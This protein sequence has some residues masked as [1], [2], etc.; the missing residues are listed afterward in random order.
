MY[1]GGG[2]SAQVSLP[3]GMP[4]RRD[5]PALCLRGIPCRRDT[6]HAPAPGLGGGTP[7]APSRAGAPLQKYLSKGDA[8][9]PAVHPRTCYL[10]KRSY[11][12]PAP[13]CRPAVTPTV[14]PTAACP[15]R[16]RNTAPQ[17][18]PRAWLPE[19]AS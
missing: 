7:P 14:T 13:A 9:V 8:I 18:Y 19:L 17:F 5:T 15:R 16:R 6:R 3:A 1:K 10:L 12:R 2:E 4:P 11:P